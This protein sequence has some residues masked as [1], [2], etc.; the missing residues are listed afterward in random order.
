MFLYFL[1]KAMPVTKMNNEYFGIKTSKFIIGR[2]KYCCGFFFTDNSHS[3]ISY[4]M[5][6]ILGL[7]RKIYGQKVCNLKYKQNTEY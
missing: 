7:R 1:Q 4:H 3:I 5:G 6:Y 2:K